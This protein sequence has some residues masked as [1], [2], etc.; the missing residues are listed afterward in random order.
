MY[1]VIYQKNTIKNII[2][3]SN[4]AEN[5][6]ETLKSKNIIQKDD[7][8]KIFDNIKNMGVK[9]I[10]AIREDG[11]VMSLEE[12]IKNK[13][14]ILEKDEE[15]RNGQIYKL[16]K[17]IEEDLIKLIELGIE[18]LDKNKKIAEGNGKKYITEKSME[19]KL[20]EGLIT[21]EEY[22]NHIIQLRQSQYYQNLDGKRAELLDDVLHKLASQ[23]LLTDE[24][25]SNLNEL[26][27]IR[28][29]I[30]ESNPK[31]EVLLKA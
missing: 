23:G 17:N 13:I 11:S 7:E 27:N 29:E 21:Q 25:K 10:R 1:I 5:T 9:D 19:E 6:I 16:D 15:I 2:S 8:Y 30:K 28:K 22:N 3:S 12:Q 31:A 24:Q 26:E 18:K 14:V 20:K 4:D